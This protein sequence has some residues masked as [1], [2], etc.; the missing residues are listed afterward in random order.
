MYRLQKMY[1]MKADAN[2]ILSM[3]MRLEH[4]PVYKEKSKEDQAK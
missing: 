1:Q 2:K 4:D 3:F